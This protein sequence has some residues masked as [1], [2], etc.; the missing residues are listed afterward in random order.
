MAVEDK[1]VHSQIVAGRTTVP[2]LAAQGWPIVACVATF[3]TAAANDD[4]SV[5]RL[6]PSIPSSAIPK[7]LRIACDAITGMTD[8]D[9]G[10]YKPG[11]GGA[12]VDKDILAD[13]VNPSAGYSR[14]L[15]LDG[16][17]TVDLANALKPLW[18]LVSGTTIINRPATYDI[19]LTANT[20]GSGVGTITAYFEY[21]NP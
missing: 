14:I 4:G 11:V 10:L 5:F 8:V 18:E 7:M 16:L 21:W 12:E 3:E 6:F 19:C 15:A 2:G 17:V 9:L 1:Y 13:G 20:M